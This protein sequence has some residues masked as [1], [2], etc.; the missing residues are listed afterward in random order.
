MTFTLQTRAD[1]QRA[2]AAD[3]DRRVEATLAQQEA[4]T[5]PVRRDLLKQLGQ[6]TTALGKVQ[7]PLDARVDEA[8]Y[9]AITCAGPAHER[10]QRAADLERARHDRAEATAPLAARADALDAQL[11]ALARL[12]VEAARAD[13]ARRHEAE[14]RRDRPTQGS[15][16]AWLAVF[17]EAQAALETVHR[18]RADVADACGEILARVPQGVA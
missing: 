18:E 16:R 10:A 3:A 2:I 4:D 17:R 9:A 1:V 13:L 14:M 11:R 6:A 15:R 5:V 8:T 7:R 12:P